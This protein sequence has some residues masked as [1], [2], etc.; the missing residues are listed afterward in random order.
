M[1]RGVLDFTPAFVFF[2]H[3][4]QKHDERQ[5]RRSGEQQRDDFLS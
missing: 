4:D 3:S 2:P 1:G 5:Q